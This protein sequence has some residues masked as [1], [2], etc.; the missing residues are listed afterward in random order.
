MCGKVFY[1][2]NNFGIANFSLFV[3]GAWKYIF[4]AIIFI[5]AAFIHKIEVFF[6]DFYQRN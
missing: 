2:K 6:K 4:K 1:V 3:I 5:Q